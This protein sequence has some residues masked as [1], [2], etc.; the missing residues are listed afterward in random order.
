MKNNLLAILILVSMSL[1]TVMFW[2]TNR[3]LDNLALNVANTFKSET[4]IFGDT[5]KKTFES[6]IRI[7][8]RS[9]K[10]SIVVIPPGSFDTA[11]VISRFFKT[12]FYSWSERD[13]SIS[14]TLNDSI[15][16]NRILFRDFSYKILKPTAI[17]TITTVATPEKA[18]KI[19][20]YIGG[21][22]GFDS[23][24]LSQLQPTFGV[25]FKDWRLDIGYDILQ[26][27]PTIGVMKKL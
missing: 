22:T 16:R 2:L 17:T 15:G 8:E 13:S 18:K 14:F 10:D 5:T 23:L 24:R 12:H 6:P 9:H 26:K 25:G 11:E 21:K 4:K 27:N 20:V 7:I 19:S 1:M 3:H